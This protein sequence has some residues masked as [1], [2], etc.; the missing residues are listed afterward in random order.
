MLDAEENREV[1]FKS[2]TSAQPPTLPW[3]IMDK[4]KKFICAC[5]NADSKGI[6]YF[7]VGDCQEQS[8]KFKRGEILGL[9]V[10]DV[11]D[12]I[13]K[14]FQFVLDDHIKS[15]AGQ[16]QK[17]GDQNCINLEF[18]PVTSG[19]AR[20]RLYVIEI[21]VMRDWKLCKENVYYTKC[22]TE[23]RGVK[24]DKDPSTKKSLTDFFKVHKDEFDDVAIR[25]NG[26]STS[27][28][29]HE[30]NRQ[31]REPLLAKYKEW[32]REAK[33]GE[34]EF[35]CFVFCFVSFFQEIL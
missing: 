17:G 6:I 31:V 25:T 14:A 4:A 34:C 10:E 1:E 24:I 11:I 30:V 22:W 2:F 19:G 27:V 12:D 32:K 23:K 21:E 5:L 28:K 15:D 20:T 33:L 29:K 35:F 3:K 8:S 13:M 9:D 16:L 26:A 7:G 18:V